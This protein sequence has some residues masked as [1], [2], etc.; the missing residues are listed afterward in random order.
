MIGKEFNAVMTKHSFVS[1]QN[2][3]MV[4]VSLKYTNAGDVQTF[5]EAFEDEL[6]TSNIQNMFTYPV[7]WSKL[8]FDVADY[9]PNYYHIEFDEIEFFARLL[10]IQITR[11]SDNGIDTFEYTINL[12]KEV[13]A[14]NADAIVAKTYL[15]HKEEN[16]DG[17]LV[18]VDYPV[19]M[20]LADDPA[21]S[22][23]RVEDLL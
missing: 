23:E 4:E 6:D 18:A 12:I 21:K 1:R 19:L 11:K 15:K 20:R 22:R 7:R 2:E 9:D 5:M 16:E 3:T 8:T 14:D 17:K 13:G 10:N